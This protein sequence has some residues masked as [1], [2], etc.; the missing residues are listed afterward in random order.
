MTT[1]V[2]TKNNTNV[3][4]TN[5]IF[6]YPC[7]CYELRLS[8]SLFSSKKY[9][10][11]IVRHK[12]WISLNQKERY[13]GGKL[14]HG[15]QNNE[16]ECVQKVV[17]KCLCVQNQMFLF[18]LDNCNMSCTIVGAART[19]LFSHVTFK[20]YRY[21]FIFDFL[22]SQFGII[23]IKIHIRSIMNYLC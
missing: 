16:I 3:D 10:I 2:L 6:F 20:A 8:C 23:L 17:V 18:L 13:I 5:F 19:F 1:K 7:F 22:M 9:G 21:T 14:K 11:M 4:Y 15:V 12:T